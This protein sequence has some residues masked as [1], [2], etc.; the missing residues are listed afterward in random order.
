MILGA[1]QWVNGHG[2]GAYSLLLGL[3]WLLV[4][5]LG[6]AGAAL[7][8]SAAYTVSVGVL[9]WRFAVA[10]EWPLSRVL[11]PGAALRQDLRTVFTCGRR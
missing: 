11:W 10:A 8:A 9:A 5:Q 3:A 6:M 1:G 7:A 4:P 2:W